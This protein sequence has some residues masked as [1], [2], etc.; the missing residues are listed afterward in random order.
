MATVPIR[1]G[2]PE[3]EGPRKRGAQP[4]NVNAMRVKPFERALHNLLRERPR[5]LP[6]I[7]KRLVLEAIKGESWAIKD[8]RE[9]LDGKAVQA[10]AGV[11]EITPA[12]PHD[13]QSRLSQLVM[14]A[15]QRDNGATEFVDAGVVEAPSGG[16]SADDASGAAGSDDAAGELGEA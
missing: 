8:V 2:P 12:D 11:F 10:Y 5:V 4:G 3:P 13:V 14:G 1:R 16:V 15:L 7:M 6:A 9:I